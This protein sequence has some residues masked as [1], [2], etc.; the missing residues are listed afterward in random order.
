VRDA[1]ATAVAKELGVD[2]GK[3]KAAFDKARP[4][5]PRRA[6]PRRDPVA[7]IADALGVSE[8]RLRAAL[9]AAGTTVGRPHP[10]FGRLEA[11]LADALGVSTARLRDALAQVRAAAL[12]QERARRAAFARALA[13]KLSLPVQKVQDALLAG[14]FGDRHDG[15]GWHRRGPGGPDRPHWG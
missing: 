6:G 7:T 3:V 13:A 15:P 11:D 12:N 2:A 1:F 8:A 5:G 14:P 4:H 10:G 9:R